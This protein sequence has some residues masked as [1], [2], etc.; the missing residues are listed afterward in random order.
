MAASFCPYYLT[1][2]FFHFNKRNPNWKPNG[3]WKKSIIQFPYTLTGQWE[4]Q[5]LLWLWHK[6]EWEIS[7]REG[8]HHAE[9]RAE[10]AGLIAL[11]G[12]LWRNCL[13]F[14]S[15]SHLKLFCGGR[16]FG[17]NWPSRWILFVL[18]SSS[19]LYPEKAMLSAT[20][21]P[22]RIQLRLPFN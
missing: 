12:I 22:N 11:S 9:D 2:Q 8:H 4:M 18:A 16:G 14:F 15:E 10:M 5:A 7:E 3:K 6:S 19:S 17:C 20:C 21:Y 1:E 13:V